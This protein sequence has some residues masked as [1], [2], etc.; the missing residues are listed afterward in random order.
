LDAN[1]GWAVGNNGTV[2]HTVNSGSIWFKQP[3][4]TADHIKEIGFSEPL[5]GWLA[6]ASDSIFRTVNGGKTWISENTK[7]TT[8]PPAM[9]FADR[10]HGWV[11]AKNQIQYTADGGLTFTSLTSSTGNDMRAATFVVPEPSTLALLGMS[12]F[13]FLAWTWRRGCKVLK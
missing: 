13:G 12:V 7:A 4:A 2:L 6:V 10:N 8:G 9:T 11:F 5:N 3:I 1:Q